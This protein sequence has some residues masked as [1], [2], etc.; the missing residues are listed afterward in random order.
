MS[1]ETANGTSKPAWI[2]NDVTSLL[3]ILAF[4]LH[5]G[6]TESTTTMCLWKGMVLMTSQSNLTFD[7]IT[8]QPLK[9]KLAA[10]GKLV[11][12]NVSIDKKIDAWWQ[13]HCVISGQI[14]QKLTATGLERNQDTIKKSDDKITSMRENLLERMMYE[15]FKEDPK[16]Q[17][18]L[19]TDLH[20]AIGSTGVVLNEHIFR[21]APSTTGF[22]GESR[23]LRWLF[24]QW[25]TYYIV[26]NGSA[27]A[28]RKLLEE[29]RGKGSGQPR[30]KL[31]AFMEA[32]FI[33]Q[34]RT[35]GMAFGSSQG[36]CAGCAHALDI[37]GAARGKKGNMFKQWLDPLDLSGEQGSTQLKA[38]IRDH[39]LNLVLSDFDNS[40]DEDA[41]EET[42]Q[43][44]QAM[45]IQRL[46]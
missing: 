41:F 16:K 44:Y 14:G 3:E 4:A 17:L 25:A 34:T 36:T 30:L 21:K 23:I 9:D 28:I 7:G 43:P 37:C 35:W 15:F 11:L 45:E 22:H 32:E 31:I 33:Q 40:T 20:G 13:Q 1:L 10:L 5:P 39:A 18:A 27:H 29:S 2:K 26:V 38:V 42:D 19:I 6:S 12:E 8:A 46:S 24:I